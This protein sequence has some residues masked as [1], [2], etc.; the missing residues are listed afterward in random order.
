MTM[1]SH[2]WFRWLEDLFWRAIPEV[3]KSSKVAAA[4][5]AKDAD[6][7]TNAGRRDGR[8]P[9]YESRRDQ[10]TLRSL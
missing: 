9:T 8:P 10:I 1:R 2:P 7:I 6:A 5:F 3:E 4:A